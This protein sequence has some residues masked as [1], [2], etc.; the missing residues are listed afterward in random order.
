MAGGVNF[1]LL[2]GVEGGGGS[3]VILWPCEQEG[4]G[5]A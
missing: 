3:G 1:C 4:A 2:A 5:S